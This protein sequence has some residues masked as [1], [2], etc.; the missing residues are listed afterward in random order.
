LEQQTNQK[1][2]G[3]DIQDETLRKDVETWVSESGYSS[4]PL[5]G[6]REAIVSQLTHSPASIVVFDIHKPFEISCALCKDLKLDPQL[7][8]IALIG[9]LNDYKSVREQFKGKQQIWVRPDVY[10]DKPVSKEEFLRYLEHLEQERDALLQRR[11]IPFRIE[12]SL[13]TNMDNLDEQNSFLK[14]VLSSQ[15]LDQETI[16]NIQCALYEM[17][18]NALE[19]GNKWNP[20]RFTHIRYELTSELLKIAVSDEGEGFNSK[21]YMTDDYKALQHQDEREQSGKRLG[22]FG[23]TIARRYF[24]RIYYNHLGNIA[25]LEKKLDT[26]NVQSQTKVTETV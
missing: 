13:P 11:E 20:E 25:Y 8:S 9:I 6:D 15:S 17:V 12:I 24:D 26:K 2:I 18:V 4:F 14:D 1:L 22:G 7:K 21:L 23:I 19:W 16:E 3:L 5:T 10:L